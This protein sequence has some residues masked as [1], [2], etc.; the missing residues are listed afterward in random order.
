MFM[1][2]SADFTRPLPGT[3]YGLAPLSQA[4]KGPPPGNR[5]GTVKSCRADLVTAAGQFPWP[6]AGSYLAVCGQFLAAVVTDPYR[7]FIGKD[8]ITWQGNTRNSL[9]SS[10][11]KQPGWSWKR[12]GRSRALPASSG[13]TR[14]RLVTGCGPTVRSTPVTSRR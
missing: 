9:L 13:L 2:S 5:Q 1:I 14:R 10:V 11:R 4:G 12:P 3:E 8:G 7:I 6:P